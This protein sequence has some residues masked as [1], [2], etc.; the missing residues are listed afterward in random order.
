MGIKKG[1][2]I[3]FGLERAFEIAENDAIAVV[4]Y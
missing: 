4:K 3:I 2:F 1:G